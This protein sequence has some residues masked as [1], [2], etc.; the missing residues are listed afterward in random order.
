MEKEIKKKKENLLKTKLV[1]AIFALVAFTGGFLFLNKS[2]TGNIILNDKYSFNLVSLIG[3]LLILCAV[4][5]GVYS[6]KKKNN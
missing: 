6:V 1:T 2:I 4:I 5:L 3:L